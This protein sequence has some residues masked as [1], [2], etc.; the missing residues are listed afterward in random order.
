MPPLS[1]HAVAPA[2]AVVDLPPPPQLVDPALEFFR[3]TPI[4]TV[5][6]SPSLLVKLV[7]DSYRDVSGG[8]GPEQVL[9]LHA[10]DFFD[11]KVTLPPPGSAR[12]AIRAAQETKRPSV[13]E[14]SQPDGSTWSIRVVPLFRHG[15][16]QY[17][18]MEL[19]D[20]TEEHQKRL[21]LESQ[22][23]TNETFRILVETVK[24][25]AI[26]MLDPEGNVA[27]WNAGAQ[28]FKGY[29]RDE[30]IGKHFSN[31][32]SKEDRDNDK[33]GRE[34]IDALRDGRVE[35]EGWRYRKDGSKFW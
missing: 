28:V 33:P 25:Y 34:L 26:F 11:K 20:V 7:S 27:S 31:F 1:P 13:L 19:T 18:Q 35:D 5:I 30:I 24:D 10:D 12:K 32:Y 16:L 21:E 22:L 8:C 2:S 17:L 6:L 3:H 15:S 23:Y 14:V 29:T 9:G 4:P